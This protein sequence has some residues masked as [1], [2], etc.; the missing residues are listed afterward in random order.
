[1]TAEDEVKLLRAEFRG[2]IQR[3]AVLGYPEE[4]CDCDYCTVLT[5][6]KE[7]LEKHE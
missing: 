4:N 6:A 3:A 5:K 1:M 7:A 2:L